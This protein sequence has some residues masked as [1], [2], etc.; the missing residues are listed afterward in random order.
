VAAILVIAVVYLVLV[1]GFFVP[2]NYFWST[3][4]SPYGAHAPQYEVLIFSVSP[5][6][7]VMH[8]AV[9]ARRRPQSGGVLGV[10][11]GDVLLVRR[12]DRVRRPGRRG[13]DR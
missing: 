8:T 13:G 11:A 6:I 7:N 3:S 10:R 5:L 1:L 12:D 4:T 9:G 2:G